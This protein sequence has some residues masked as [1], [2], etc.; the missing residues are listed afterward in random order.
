MTAIVMGSRHRSRAREAGLMTRLSHGCTHMHSRCSKH[1]E[2]SEHVARSYCKGDSKT[3][4]SA[5]MRNLANRK[6]EP[7]RC[8]APK[9]TP[10]TRKERR[11]FQGRDLRQSRPTQMRGQM[12]CCSRCLATG[13]LLAIA[14]VRR[15]R[16]RNRYT[17]PTAGQA[18]LIARTCA[19]AGRS[20]NQR[21]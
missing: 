3:S 6:D 21:Q 7:V 4:G 1:S 5:R 11:L 14:P 10:P 12:Y 9:P 17:A 2:A 15:G 20:G 18:A 19:S 8:R 16:G 13:S